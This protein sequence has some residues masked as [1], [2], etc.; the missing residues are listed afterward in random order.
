MVVAASGGSASSTC[1]RSYSGRKKTQEAAG[2]SP[3][4][5]HGGRRVR[6]VRLLPALSLAASQKLIVSRSRL[7]LSGRAW[8][9]GL[10]WSRAVCTGGGRG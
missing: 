5:G 1:H 4:L 6:E 8:V 10:H 3:A 2:Q 9:Q 7:R